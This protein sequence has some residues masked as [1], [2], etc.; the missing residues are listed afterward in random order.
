[1]KMYQIAE[2]SGAKA[3]AGTKATEDVIHIAEDMGF[4]P[5]YI[6]M[7]D[8]KEGLSHKILRQICFAEDWKEAYQKID[9][10]SIVLLQHPFHYPQLTREKLLLKLKQKKK[11]RYISVIHD[12]EELRNLGKEEYHRH[13]FEFMLKIADVF[14]VHNN[15]MR[16]YF[17]SKGVPKGKLVTL[18]IFDYLRDSSTHGLPEFERSVT[19]AGN[20]DVKKSGYLRNLSEINCRFRLYGPNYSLG[21]VSNISYGGILPPDRIPDVLNKGFGLIWDGDSIERCKGGFGDYLRYN[22][23]HK[24]SLYLSAGLPVIIWD[25]AAEA[26]FVKKNGLG[27]TVS[28]LIDLPEVLESTNLEAYRKISEK[29]SIISQ[30]LVHGDFMKGAIGKAM[31]VINEEGYETG[32]FSNEK[33]EKTGK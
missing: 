31:A 12:V 32:E 24:L 21:Q 2:I 29:V 5:L 16:D 1:M 8:T 15:A 7:K 14:I 13:E 17:I 30:K 19:I 27:L 9:A 25:Q 11:V 10:G 3:H 33:C 23:P 20:L 26:H 22:N 18:G 28:S 4:Q 6:R